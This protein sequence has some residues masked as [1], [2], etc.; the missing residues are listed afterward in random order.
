MSRSE[1]TTEVATGRKA[2]AAETGVSRIED[3]YIPFVDIYGH[4]DDTILEVD[5]PGVDEKSIEVN[6]ENNILTISAS[7][8]IA[9]PEGHRI[10]RQEFKPAC[11]R[12]EF[13][14]THEVDKAGIKARLNNG[15]LTVVLPK[16]EAAKA[17]K[18]AVSAG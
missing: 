8:A 11:Y 10:A 1:A 4:K 16:G 18:I 2:A 13:E 7:T 15:V 12:R 5:L 14:L 17:R 9:A 3:T 6:L